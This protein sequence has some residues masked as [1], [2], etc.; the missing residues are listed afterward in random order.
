MAF[1]L[2]PRISARVRH[3]GKIGGCCGKDTP[4]LSREEV[5]ARIPLL[6]LWVLS[7]DGA[8]ISRCFVAKNWAAA[9]SFLNEALPPWP[10]RRGEA[11]KSHCHRRNGR[12]KSTRHRILV[13]AKRA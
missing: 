7:P 3:R 6:P 4:G 1:A 8:S 5:L 12:L 11:K 10:P 13:A 2:L 9:M